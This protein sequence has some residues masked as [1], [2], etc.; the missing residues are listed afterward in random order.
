MWS[1]QNDLNMRALMMSFGEGYASGLL[2][3]NVIVSPCSLFGYCSTGKW[4][5]PC[6]SSYCAAWNGHEEPGERLECMC[7]YISKNFPLKMV[8]LNFC[9]GISGCLP[10]EECFEIVLLRQGGRDLL[11]SPEYIAISSVSWLS[12]LVMT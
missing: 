5:W 10:F 4:S 7:H 3:T 9:T 2:S 8:A 1:K 12:R 11:L 6:F